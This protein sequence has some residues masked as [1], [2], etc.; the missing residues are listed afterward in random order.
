MRNS[1]KLVQEYIWNGDW[2]MT[3][4]KCTTIVLKKGGDNF[5]IAY[6]EEKIRYIELIDIYARFIYRIITK[7]RQLGLTG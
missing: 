1:F 7:L 6:I 5:F 4:T 3:N 2:E